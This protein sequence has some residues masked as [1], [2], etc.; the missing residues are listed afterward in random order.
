MP[1]NAEI[2]AMN[3]VATSSM[4]SQSFEAGIDHD[5]P[6]R[7]SEEVALPG[8]VE[9]AAFTALGIHARERC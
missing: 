9:D 6:S 5:G 2:L 8:T 4:D 1:A 7:S 3:G